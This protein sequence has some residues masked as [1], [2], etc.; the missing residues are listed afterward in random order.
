MDLGETGGSGK[1]EGVRRGRLQERL[2]YEGLIIISGTKTIIITQ[3]SERINLIRK[4]KE[5][6]RMHAGTEVKDSAL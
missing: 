5:T 1:L 3:L 4:T 6:I 2:L